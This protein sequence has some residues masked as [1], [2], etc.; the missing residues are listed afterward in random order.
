MVAR[1]RRLLILLSLAAL[2]FPALAAAETTIVFRE[3][4]FPY[5][6][7]VDDCGF[8]LH[9]T[10]T[11][12]NWLKYRYE[13]LP[14]GFGPGVPGVQLYQRAG[15]HHTDYRETWTNPVTGTTL[16][17]H[18][19]DRLYRTDFSFAG[20][21][22]PVTNRLTGI[23]T[24]TVSLSYSWIATA[25]GEGVVLQDTGHMSYVE[26]VRFTNGVVTG[27]RRSLLRM[28][29]QYRDAFCQYLAG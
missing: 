22:D 19:T 8:D 26:Q 17:V 21:V 1:M 15:W 5:E 11:A 10:G 27:Q 20:T 23:L 3:A 14:D 24:S 2:A 7:T 18:G 29:G 4:T 25:P 12:A 28:S 6:A 16:D 9:V 13:D